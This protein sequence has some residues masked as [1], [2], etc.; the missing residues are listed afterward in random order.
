M[1]AVKK[2]LLFVLLLGVAV[3]S[4]GP[5]ERGEEGEITTGGGVGREVSYSQDVYPILQKKCSGCHGTGGVASSTRYK[6]TGDA[7]ADY[8]TIKA[9]VNTDNPD[10]SELLE[11]GSG[12]ESHGGGKQLDDNEYA[13][14]K[15]WIEQG[16]KNN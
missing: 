11:K 8:G 5:L 4:C 13:I 14:I 1:V 16:A 2:Y 12:R 3:I 6:L 10:D 15:S 7:S 9:L